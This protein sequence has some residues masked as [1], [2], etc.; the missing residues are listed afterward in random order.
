M[1]VVLGIDAAWTLTQ[2]SGVAL[3]QQEGDRWR[4]VDVRSSYD[5]FHSRAGLATAF[6]ARP[7]GHCQEFRVRRA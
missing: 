1:R 3:V 6:G 5:Q 4:L 2:P 7:D